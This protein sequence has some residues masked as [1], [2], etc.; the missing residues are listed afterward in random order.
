MSGVEQPSLESIADGED[1]S[2]AK[3]DDRIGAP[4]T[5]RPEG[6]GTRPIIEGQRRLAGGFIAKEQDTAGPDVNARLALVGT[7]PGRQREEEIR[8]GF[9]DDRISTCQQDPPVREGG[10]VRIGRGWLRGLAEGATRRI[11]QPAAD[12]TCSIHAY[13][14]DTAVVQECLRAPRRI[15]PDVELTPTFRVWVEH[16]RL[17]RA[18]SGTRHV[19]AGDEHPAVIQHR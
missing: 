10:R 2:V 11:E 15:T 9:I 13:D 14:Q 3:R 5:C 18:A 8:S 7:R 17:S 1:P 19:A 6:E 12:V 4:E 16:I